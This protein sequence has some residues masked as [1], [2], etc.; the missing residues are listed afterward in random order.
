MM[1]ARLRP[2]GAIPVIGV[3]V[4]GSMAMLGPAGPAAAFLPPDKPAVA[5]SGPLKPPGPRGR[6]A[7]FRTAHFGM[8][9]DEVLAAVKA[10][11]PST[12]IQPKS[13]FYRLQGT[14]IMTIALP[15]LDPFAGPV[16]VAYTFGF[17]TH[18]LIQ[19]RATWTL[20]AGATPTDGDRLAVAARSYAQRMAAYSWRV[21][22]GET[23]PPSAD[24]ATV[25]YVASDDTGARMEM[26]AAPMPGG[27]GFRQ[28]TLGFVRNAAVQDIFE[29]KPGE[30]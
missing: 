7:G 3:L 25:L 14:P 27:A 18:S 21:T 9:R 1:A 13:D 15:A 23:D 8:S 17:K 10:D 12:D 16:V 11:F 6:I 30:F 4:L 19:V 20:P 29:I 5:M 2:K 26:L 22:Q 28:L 24:Q